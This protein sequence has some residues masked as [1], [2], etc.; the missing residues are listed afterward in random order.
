MIARTP[1]VTDELQTVQTP[2]TRRVGPE[3]RR[4]PRVDLLLVRVPTV[5]VAVLQSP[6]PSH[7]GSVLRPDGPLSVSIPGVVPSFPWDTVSSPGLPPVRRTD[8][9]EAGRSGRLDDSNVHPGS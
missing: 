7:E 5:L 3:V 4:P 9:P 1:V 6:V 2:A 8:S